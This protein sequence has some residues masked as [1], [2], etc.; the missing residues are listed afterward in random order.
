MPL[1]YIFMIPKAEYTW[2]ELIS[3]DALYGINFFF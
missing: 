2:F 3:V 1:K